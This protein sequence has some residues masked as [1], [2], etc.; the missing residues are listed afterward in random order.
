MEKKKIFVGKYAIEAFIADSIQERTYGLMGKKTLG[1]DE[2]MLFIFDF[3]Q[4]VS[5]WMYDTNLYL[6]IAF[7]DANGILLEFYNLNPLDKTPI[8]SKADNIVYALEVRQGWFTA[9]GLRPIKT[10]LNVLQ[11][12]SQ[13]VT[14]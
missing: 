1:K 12:H 13:G 7:F 3:P 5:F 6:D 4:R 8:H 11:L 10:R 2:G 14:H 9:R